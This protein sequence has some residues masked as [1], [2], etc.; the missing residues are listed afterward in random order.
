MSEMGQ[1]AA[2]ATLLH[3][4]RLMSRK[5]TFGSPREGPQP[6]QQLVS[7]AARGVGGGQKLLKRKAT[8]SPQRIRSSGRF[9]TRPYTNTSNCDVGGDAI[10]IN[11]PL[12]IDLMRPNRP[13]AD[14]I[15]H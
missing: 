13:K 5:P 9:T 1:K 7:F 12:A 2:L 10:E 3:L 15:A 8:N 6:A 14:Q 4:G 11:L